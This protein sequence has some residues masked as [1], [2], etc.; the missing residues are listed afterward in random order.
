MLGCV[1]KMARLASSR[2]RFARWPTAAS[3]NVLQDVTASASEADALRESEQQL[4]FVANTVPALLAFVDNDA[5]YVWVNESYRRWFGQAPETIRGR[6]VREVLGQER[7]G[8]GSAP[9]RAGP[10]R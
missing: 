5:R 1:V 9:N 10:G 2:R 6:H 7:L 8:T 4:Q 3:I